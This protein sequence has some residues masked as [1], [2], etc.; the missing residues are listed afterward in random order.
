M[1]R[2]CRAAVVARPMLLLLLL[3][4][5]L[6]QLLL[7]M[8]L[9]LL[10]VNT[11]GTFPEASPGAFRKEASPKAP[12]GR[13]TKEFSQTLPQSISPE[14]SPKA[15]PRTSPISSLG[16][17]VELPQGRRQESHHD[18]H[19]GASPRTFCEDSRHR[20]P[21]MCNTTKEAMQHDSNTRLKG[22]QND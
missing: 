9:L 16:F 1:E 6:L 12:S 8:K 22:C 3:L 10:L 4:L 2:R 5:L 17:P 13:S 19:H 11:P 7:P 18:P 14:A 15:F 20:L 21:S